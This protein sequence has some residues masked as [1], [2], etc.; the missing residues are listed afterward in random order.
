MRPLL[1]VQD[2][3]FLIIILYLNGLIEMFDPVQSQYSTLM[4]IVLFNQLSTV[5]HYYHAKI[6]LHC[7]FIHVTIVFLNYTYNHQNKFG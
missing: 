2:G 1:Q 4:V 6:P 7:K 5:K 3:V